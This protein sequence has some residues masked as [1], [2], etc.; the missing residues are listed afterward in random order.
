MIF[1]T[2]AWIKLV[3]TEEL[4]QDLGLE[5]LG[6]VH[7]DGRHL[8]LVGRH[9]HPNGRRTGHFMAQALFPT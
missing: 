2:A 3:T 6:G 5:E 1:F 8:R 7:L 4:L 9:V